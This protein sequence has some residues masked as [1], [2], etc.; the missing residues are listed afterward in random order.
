[1]PM[2]MAQAMATC[3]YK[4]QARCMRM[5]TH[6]IT[7]ALQ[8]SNTHM[9]R[10]QIEMLPLRTAQARRPKRLDT[11]MLQGRRHIRINVMNRRME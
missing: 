10:S 4:V 9:M 7:M 11:P 1:M 3:P 2:S 6:I 5:S 8:K